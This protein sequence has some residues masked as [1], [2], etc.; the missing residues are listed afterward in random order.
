MVNWPAEPKVP[1]GHCVQ[2][3]APLEELYEP[4]EQARHTLIDVPP[5]AVP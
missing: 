2:V 1:A 4:G 3:D 5:V